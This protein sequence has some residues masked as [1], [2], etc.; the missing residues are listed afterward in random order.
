MDFDVGF[1]ADAFEFRA[2]WEIV[3]LD[4]NPEDHPT[5]K[6][7]KAG[8]KSGDSRKNSDYRLSRI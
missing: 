2:I 6:I 1:D 8:H 3:A 7:F 4:G 5:V